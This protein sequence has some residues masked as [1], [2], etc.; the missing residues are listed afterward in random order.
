MEITV[1]LSIDQVA[2]ITLEE[3]ISAFDSLEAEDIDLANSFA[4][5]IKYYATVKQWNKFCKQRG[6]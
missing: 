6:L 4:K 1:K 5:V 3:L 2:E